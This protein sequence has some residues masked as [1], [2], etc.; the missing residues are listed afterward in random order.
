[1][2]IIIAQ[3][4]T[5]SVN[6]VVNALLYPF[7]KNVY[8]YN[9]LLELFSFAQSHL[10]ETSVVICIQPV[11][12]VPGLK[13]GGRRPTSGIGN[14]VGRSSSVYNI[15][16]LALAMSSVSLICPASCSVSSVRE[17]ADEC[18]LQQVHLR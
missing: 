8:L 11:T 9:Y 14:D 16:C 13:C 3:H 10:P 4:A 5:P 2:S 7:D 6:K 15:C 17:W 1:M 12:N 18:G